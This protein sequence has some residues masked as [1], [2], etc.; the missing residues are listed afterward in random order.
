M[1]R[2]VAMGKSI[3]QMRGLSLVEL[4]VV[5]LVVALGLALRQ[6]PAGREPSIRTLSS[7]P[8][9]IAKPIEWS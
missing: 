5:L 3:D 4:M 8:R 2:R 1:V 6:V 9:R 7:A